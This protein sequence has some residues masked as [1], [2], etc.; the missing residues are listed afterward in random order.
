MSSWRT[1]DVRRFSGQK[2]CDLQ[3]LGFL[4]ILEE[5]GGGASPILTTFA[6]YKVDYQEKQFAQGVIPTT[7]MRREGAPRERE[8]LC[9]R[10][11]DRPIRPLFPAGFYHEVQVM[12]SVLSSDGKQDP[13][14]MAA[15]ATSAALMLSDIP[16]G[17]PIGVIRIG[18]I[19][20]QFIVNPSMD[21]LSLSDL[22]LVYACTRDKTLMIDVQ[23]REIS[24]KDLEAA[25][26]LAHPEAVRYLEP[27]IRLAARAGKSKKE[28]TLSMVS[29][30]TFEKV[31]N[32][33]E[34]P[35]E[36]VFT[37]HTY[38][39]F[40]RGE[41]LDLITQ[42]VKRALEEEC[43]EESLK[44][45]PKVV[46]TVRKES[47]RGLR[48]APSRLK[49][50]LDKSKLILVGEVPNVE[51]L[52]LWLGCKVGKLP[53]TYLGLPLGAPFK[54]PSAWD[55]VEERFHK[56]LLI[57]FMPL[58]VIS[59]AVTLRLAK[60]KLDFLWGEGDLKERPH[61]VKWE[62]LWRRIIVGK[63]GEELG[64]WCSLV[65]REGYDVGLWKVIRRGWEAFKARTASNKEA[66]VVNARGR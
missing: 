14:V 9:G 35:I 20:G 44:V 17:G 33:A 23:A 56:S 12:A 4:E 43:D 31:R 45:L 54:S 51:E 27:Q 13:D 25:L 16:W 36:A 26:R 18:R 8:L 1:Y 59:K 65:R 62:F 47:S 63:F 41:A 40:E 66:C 3:V 30:I 57:Y 24:E 22:N 55:V 11:I 32:L 10:L 5:L 19:C 60:V 34:A 28:Y 49:I 52:A 2:S 37:D 64:G 50:N 21:E 7:F 58:F 6:S 39:K 61:L 53:T 15:N 42:D 38:G 29:D 48:Q 46:D